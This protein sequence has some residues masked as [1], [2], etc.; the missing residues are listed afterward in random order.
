MSNYT[1]SVN[2]QLVLENVT[3]TGLDF[4][5]LDEHHFHILQ[6]GQSYLAALEKVD[7]GNKIFVFRINGE[8]YEVKIADEFDQTVERLGLH[9][10]TSAK[11]KDLKAPMP[12]LVLDIMVEIGQKI[13]K[14]DSLLILEAMKMENVL[15]SP[16]EGVVKKVKIEKG[17]AVNKGQVLLEMEP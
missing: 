9:A 5:R 14:G 17:A 10:Q 15:K 1:I 16:G 11:F 7:Y 13:Q 8:R 4:I 3:K 12:G 6:G 2:G